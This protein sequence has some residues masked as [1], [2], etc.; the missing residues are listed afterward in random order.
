M[1]E[2]II[3]GLSPHAVLCW[4][5]AADEREPA[6]E[7]ALALARS[8][9]GEC[10]VVLG[11]DSPQPL[12]PEAIGRAE[13]KLAALYGG[14]RDVPTVTMV[15]PGDPIAEVRRYARRHQVDLI[16]IGRQ[17][18]AAERR[19]GARIADSAPCALLMF[20]HAAR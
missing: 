3:P 5:D 12:T 2:S 18:L 4:V 20:L 9:A 17:A 15:L 16:V 10:H 19:L 7:L 13:R 14:E 8:G 1:G 11:L 6:F